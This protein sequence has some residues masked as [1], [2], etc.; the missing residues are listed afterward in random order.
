MLGFVNEKYPRTGALGLAI[1]GG[2]GMLSVSIVL[3]VMGRSY[4]AG[5][6]ARIPAEQTAAGL[7]A[8]P[9]GSPLAQVWTRIQADAGLATIGRI[10][11]LPVLLAVVF[12]VL[13][14][15]RRR[16]AV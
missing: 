6:A 9:A 13:V 12:L 8:A 7:A 3:P 16:K 11:W 10:A 5:I 15:A 14:L 1:M 2:A 4:D